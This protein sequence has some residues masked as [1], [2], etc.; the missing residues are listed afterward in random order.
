VGKARCKAR[1]E[2]ASGQGRASAL[3]PKPHYIRNHIELAAPPRRAYREMQLAAIAG[4]VNEE[5]AAQFQR[6]RSVPS[7]HNIPQGPSNS[8]VSDDEERNVANDRAAFHAA[9]TPGGPSQPG[10]ARLSSASAYAAQQSQDAQHEQTP[11]SAP[12][13]WSS[14][15]AS[16]AQYSPSASTR[17]VQ[18]NPAAQPRA[19]TTSSCS[20]TLVVGQH[21]RRPV[22]SN[23]SARAETTRG[24]SDISVVGQRERRRAPFSCSPCGSIP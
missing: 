2:A 6:S 14:A 15:S 21:E 7:S 20:G 16:A 3:H 18:Y 9:L 23:C 17:V 12:V 22:Q 1:G 13:H 8:H 5:R 19:D 11:S 4:P 10:Q 24:P